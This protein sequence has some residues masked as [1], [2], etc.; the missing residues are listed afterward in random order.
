MTWS[1]LGRNRPDRE[2][3][4]SLV[5]FA[6]IAPIF[7]MLVVGLIEFAVAFSVQLNVNYASRDAAL[8]AAEA[9][10]G[11]GADCIILR[12]VEKDLGSPSDKTSIQQVRVYWASPNGVEKAANIYSRSGTTSCTLADG[13]TVTVPYSASSTAYPESSRCTYLAG[14]GGTRPARPDRRLYLLSARLDH[15]VLGHGA[16]SG[17]GRDH[18][19]QQQ[20][21]HGADAV[22]RLGSA[23]S[24]FRRA[25]RRGQAL[26]ETAV[27]LPLLLTIVLGTLEFGFVFDHHLT[28]EYATREG[29][30][31]G[32]ALAN[33]G[34]TFGCGAGQSPN[35]ANVDPA[36]IAAVE[37]VL[38]SNG[39]RVALNRI[40]EIRIYEAERHTHRPDQQVRLRRRWRPRGRRQG[41]RLQGRRAADL[42]RGRR[43]GTNRSIGISL[44]YTYDLQTPLRI[45]FGWGDHQH[46]RP[47]RH[48]DQSDEPVRLMAMLTPDRSDPAAF[49]G[50]CERRPDPGRIRTER[51]LPNKPWQA[52][53]GQVL[54]IFA[55]MLTILLLASALVVDLG[56]LWKTPPDSQRAAD[57]AA[58]A[59]VVHLPADVPG[60]Y[61]TAA[62]EATKN[63]YTAGGG[64]TITPLRDP[65]VPRRLDV[66]VQAPVKTFFLGLIGMDPS[67]SPARRRRTMS[68]RCRWAARRPTT[69]SATS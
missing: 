29:A 4:Q 19:A 33:G 57:A 32:A 69:A 49:P 65:S 21:A 7:L 59:G 22:S 55:G 63:G 27:I 68:F 42:P 47:D 41:P 13:T 26:V 48:V 35:A 17:V 66:W 61:L 56:W 38:A 40:G 10:S 62:Q 30:R 43:D 25:S 14:C 50:R 67:A 5:E 46:E 44:T 12:A 53:R 2:H 11:A 58:L 28:L 18:H 39:S 31:A 51:L 20:H 37:R 15:A 9:G 23:W 52:P 45:L 8:L 1:R 54:L 36:I 3:G 64:V 34:G 16:A 24:T 60:A 6:L